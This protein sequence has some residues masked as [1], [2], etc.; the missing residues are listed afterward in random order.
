MKIKIVASKPENSIQDGI[1]KF[2]GK[3]YETVVSSDKFFAKEMKKLGEVAV[4]L[5]END[6]QLSIL[7]KDEY[8]I[9]EE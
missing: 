8:V 1:E 2:I 4:Y 6:T 3:E 7:N 5:E 9:I